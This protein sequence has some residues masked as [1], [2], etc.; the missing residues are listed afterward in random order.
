MGLRLVCDRCGRFMRNVPTKDVRNLSQQTDVCKVCTSYEES[1]I[2]KINTW[3]TRM[4][5]AIN[6]LIEQAKKEYAQ[7][8]ATQVENRLKPEKGDE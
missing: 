2:K 1:H 6:D 3:K 8:V 4:Q 5:I 7:M